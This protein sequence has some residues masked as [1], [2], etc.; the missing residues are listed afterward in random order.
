MLRLFIVGENFVCKWFIVFDLIGGQKQNLRRS[1]RG[2]VKLWRHYYNS[3]VAVE[4]PLH[5]TGPASKE[6]VKYIEQDV[7]IGFQK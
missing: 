7:L 6:N 3:S 1:H 5:L 2:Q 4:T